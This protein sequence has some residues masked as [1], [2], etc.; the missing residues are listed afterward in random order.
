MV[1]TSH[2]IILFDAECV[3][4]SYNAQFVLKFDKTAHFRLASMQSEVGAN[5]FR[6]FGIDPSDPDTIIVVEGA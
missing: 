3:L 2:P 4:C 6:K 1:E 5:L